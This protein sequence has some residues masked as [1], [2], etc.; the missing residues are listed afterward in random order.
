MIDI[1]SVTVY[2]QFD[3]QSEIVALASAETQLFEKIYEQGFS[4]GQYLGSPRSQSQAIIGQ[5]T[6]S[7][8]GLPNLQNKITAGQWDNA[9]S[10]WDSMDWDATSS[11]SADPYVQFQNFIFYLTNRNVANVSLYS[12]KYLIAQWLNVDYSQISAYIGKKYQTNNFISVIYVTIPF[13][14]TTI[15]SDYVVEYINLGFDEP[16]YYEIIIQEGA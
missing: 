7:I 5:N 4:S 2:Q 3:E 10:K 1:P 14:S 8:L 6:I 11:S 12:I 16:T 13:N 15:F 9:D